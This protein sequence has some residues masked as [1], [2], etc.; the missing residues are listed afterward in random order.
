MI[1]HLGEGSNFPPLLTLTMFPG[2]GWKAPDT[3]SHSASLPGQVPPG[4][5]QI[6]GV[7]EIQQQHL[8]PE[9]PLG[10]TCRL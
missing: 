8:Q 6:P 7:R 4:S 3:Q 10:P 5:D 1:L 9:R 2:R